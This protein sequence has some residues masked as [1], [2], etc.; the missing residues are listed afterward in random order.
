MSTNF[1]DGKL[2]ESGN[3][4]QFHADN[5]EVI[6]MDDTP[7]SSYR[8]RCS[9]VIRHQNVTITTGKEIEAAGKIRLKGTISDKEFLGSTIRYRVN[10]QNDVLLADATHHQGQIPLENGTPVNLYV[11]RNQVIIVGV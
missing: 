9:L 11:K 5:G 8:D 2:E 4:I 1:I 3:T 6:P 7:D 10:I